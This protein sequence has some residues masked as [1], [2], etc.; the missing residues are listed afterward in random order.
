M[1]AS[2]V[3]EFGV[4]RCG[5]HCSLPDCNWV[6]VAAFGGDDFDAG[7]DALDFW[8]ADEDHFQR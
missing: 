5:H 3:G 1:D 4:E 8:G 7:A 2:V 6:F